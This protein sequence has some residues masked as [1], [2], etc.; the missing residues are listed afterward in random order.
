MPDIL[1][2]VCHIRNCS[3]DL[4]FFQNILGKL[5][6]AQNACSKTN[7]QQKEKL[8]PCC[9][10]LSLCTDFAKFQ[11]HLKMFILTWNILQSYDLPYLSEETWVPLYFPL[12]VYV[13][14][15]LVY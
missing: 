2:T 1:G 8:L 5:W 15:S 10:F 3:V 9:P 12:R 7:Y 11:A 4:H 13:L 14:Y 6:L